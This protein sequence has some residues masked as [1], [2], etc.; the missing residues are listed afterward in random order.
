[1]SGFSGLAKYQK[2]RRKDWWDKGYILL[3]PKTGHKAFIYDYNALK[4][5]Y[6]SFQEKGFWEYYN[7]LK[8]SNPSS[9]TVQKVKN[10]FKRKSASENK[11]LIILYNL[12]E[13]LVIK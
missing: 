10:F 4:K 6:D 9:Y 2:F 13:Q 7:D 5:E 3:N 1:M 8:K 12:Q 11:V